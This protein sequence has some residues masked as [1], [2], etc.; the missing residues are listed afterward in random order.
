MT[1]FITLAHLKFT[2]Q[3]ESRMRDLEAATYCTLFLPKG[4]DIVK[5]MLAI[6]RHYNNMIENHAEKQR[7]SRHKWV[8]NSMVKATET[9]LRSRIGELSPP[10]QGQTEA[11]RW[12]RT[13]TESTDRQELA[14][15]IKA[16]RHLAWET[17]QGADRF[18]SRRTDQMAEAGHGLSAA[19]LHAAGG[20][21]AN[22][23]SAKEE[24]QNPR[25]G[26]A[27]AGPVRSASRSRKSTAC[28]NGTG[29]QQRDHA[30]QRQVKGRKGRKRDAPTDS[31]PVVPDG[32]VSALTQRLLKRWRNRR[33]SV[34][35]GNGNQRQLRR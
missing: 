30:R 28:E 32:S 25:F 8:F 4:S 19:T 12:F 23:R 21:H 26:Q 15:W 13:I 1:K 6:G 14:T 18:C 17:R 16:C 20:V 7:G 35:E 2:V 5:E 27:R 11:L 9:A 31:V 3:L 33:Q 24:D 10:D 34:S 29:A 22:A